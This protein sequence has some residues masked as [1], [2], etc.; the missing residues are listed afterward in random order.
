M[1]P[2]RQVFKLPLG[3][4]HNVVPERRW[5]IELARDRTLNEAPEIRT[6]RFLRDLGPPEVG[7]AGRALDSPQ[8]VRC[9]PWRRRGQL[10]NAPLHVSNLHRLD[11]SDAERLETTQLFR[12][13]GRKVT[14]S[15]FQLVAEVTHRH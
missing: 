10:A 6:I 2:R 7:P 8:D 11:R 13:L 14:A 15:P 4:S 1:A 3:A 12:Q 5:D 9:D